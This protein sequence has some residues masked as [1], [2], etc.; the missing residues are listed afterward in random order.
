M[1]K[2]GGIACI[3]VRRSRDGSFERRRLVNEGRWPLAVGIGALVVATV[4]AC[5][6]ALGPLA[7]PPASASPIAEATEIVTLEPTASSQ[8]IPSTPTP[9]TPTPGTPTPGATPR[10]SFDCSEYQDQT[11]Q[12]HFDPVLEAAFPDSV[13][14]QPLARPI[15]FSFFSQLC[16][17]GGATSFL[18][19]VPA[20]IDPATIA[21]A[22][23]FLILP[24]GAPEFTGFRASGHSADELVSAFV[25]PSA[26]PPDHEVVAGRSL[27]VLHVD[28]QTFYFYPSGD[29]LFLI[30][31]ANDA[32]LKAI[33]QALP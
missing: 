27:T 18:P 10:S 28:Q 13:G 9:G 19:A 8:P 25:A 26:S 4:A 20:G 22:Y 21:V 31:H 24:P 32:Q 17:T 11:P 29:V 5:G 14:G 7:S 6:A 30:S 16:Q 1:V 12:L 3:R 2:Q 33:L 23:A 15:S